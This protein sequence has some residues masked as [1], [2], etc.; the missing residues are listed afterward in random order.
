MLVEYND[1][2]RRTKEDERWT[3]GISEQVHALAVTTITSLVQISG[4][5]YL[6][7]QP[8]TYE[9]QLIGLNSSKSHLAIFSYRAKLANYTPAKFPRWMNFMWMWELDG[10]YVCGGSVVRAS[11]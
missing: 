8:L 4:N 11:A 7:I 1:F 3:R 10:K 5:S 6:V 9:M 2:S